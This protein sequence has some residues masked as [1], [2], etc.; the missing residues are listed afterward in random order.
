MDQ[1][2]FNSQID[3]IT[4]YRSPTSTKYYHTP[5]PYSDNEITKSVCANV[6]DTYKTCDIYTY[7]Y[8][9]GVT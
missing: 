9:Q 5:T 3:P 4:F 2:V 6:I 1:Y 8:I 7:I